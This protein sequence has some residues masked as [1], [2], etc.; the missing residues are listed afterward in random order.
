[1]THS[2]TAHYT[3]GCV[4]PPMLKA[5]RCSPLAPNAVF[6]WP[7]QPSPSLGSSF[8]LSSQTAVCPST[9]VLKPKVL[10]SPSRPVGG[11]LQGRWEPDTRQRALPLSGCAEPEEAAEG[12]AS[13]S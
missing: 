4:S 11:L 3:D 10:V 9:Y 6:P 13:G 2:P 1:M 5:S 7:G 12:R 8:G